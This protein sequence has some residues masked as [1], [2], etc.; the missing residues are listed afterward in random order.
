[1]YLVFT[2]EVEEDQSLPDEGE[3]FD[4]INDKWTWL[5][6]TFQGVQDHPDSPIR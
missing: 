3:R 6:A 5:D 1:M 2:V 4:V